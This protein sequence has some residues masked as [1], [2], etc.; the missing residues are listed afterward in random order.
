[1]YT[2]SYFC[3]R[4]ETRMECI[5]TSNQCTECDMHYLCTD[6]HMHN[7]NWYEGGSIYIL[8]KQTAPQIVLFFRFVC[9]LNSSMVCFRHINSNLKRK[10]SY[11]ISAKSH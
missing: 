9:H 4:M 6:R 3:K 1:M 5:H 11:Q 10:L 8:Y 7:I 2:G